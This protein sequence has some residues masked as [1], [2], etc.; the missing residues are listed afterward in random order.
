MGGFGSMTFIRRFA[1]L[2]SSDGREAFPRGREIMI[3][4]ERLKAIRELKKM[5]QGDIEKRTG[6]LRCYVSRV[7]NGHTV[8]A[9]ETL[10]KWARALD[11]HVA[12][13]FLSDGAPVPRDILPRSKKINALPRGA[14]N[15]VLKF[16]HAAASL[17]PR[18]QNLL[19]SIARKMAL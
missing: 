11:V 10:E 7:E 19:L 1:R 17:R 16:A 8:P 13:L 9:I 3:L 15:R 18:D 12:Q 14:Q 4:G 5:S 2:A 6:L